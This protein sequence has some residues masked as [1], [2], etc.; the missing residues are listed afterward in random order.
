MAKIGVYDF[1]ERDGV[2]TI[3]VDG[4]KEDLER[5]VE[6]S[7]EAKAQFYEAPNIE[8]TRKGQWT[9]LMKIKIAEEVSEA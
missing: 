2:K 8:P 4:D 1:G 5:I 9:M 6:K 3:R 7:L